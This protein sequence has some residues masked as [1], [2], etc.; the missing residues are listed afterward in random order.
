MLDLAPGATG[1]GRQG[2]GSSPCWQPPALCLP[3][4]L[5][6]QPHWGKALALT[7]G[8]S[9]RPKA[10][11]LCSLGDKR[12]DSGELGWL[13]SFSQPWGAVARRNG[14]WH[15]PHCPFPCCMTVLPSSFPGAPALPLSTPQL[16]W[17][18]QKHHPPELEPG[19]HHTP[20]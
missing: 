2:Q 15:G 7:D 10:H 16:G 9:L 20:A 3:S 11:L 14:S 4:P 13:G 6:P 17:Q 8:S 19:L 5:L 12:D 1:T 18:Q